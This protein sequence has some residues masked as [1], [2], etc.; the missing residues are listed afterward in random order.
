MEYYTLQPGELECLKIIRVR[1]GDPFRFTGHLFYMRKLSPQYDYKTGDVLD[2]K[3]LATIHK[4]YPESQLI[5]NEVMIIVG[6]FERYTHPYNGP[7]TK[8]LVQYFWP[9]VPMEEMLTVNTDELKIQPLTMILR[10]F[11]S[12]TNPGYE[13]ISSFASINIDYRLFPELLK[14][15]KFI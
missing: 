3:L 7:S 13:H 2:E 6:Q 9:E 4:V 10:L 14:T 5:I 11:I 1:G 8:R 15:I 12:E